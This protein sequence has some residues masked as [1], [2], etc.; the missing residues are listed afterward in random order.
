MHDLTRISDGVIFVFKFVDL[1]DEY[2]DD[3]IV[4]LV[5]ALDQVRQCVHLVAQFAGLGQ[6]SI[7]DAYSFQVLFLQVPLILVR[8]VDH[9]L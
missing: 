1:I 2:S 7:H 3:L 5:D 9:F 6:T 4:L 8:R